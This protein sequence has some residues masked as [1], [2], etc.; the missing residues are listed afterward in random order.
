MIPSGFC[1]FYHFGLHS[2]LKP[3][4]GHKTGTH[5]AFQEQHAC[6]SV[7]WVIRRESLQKVLRSSPNQTV[8][9]PIGLN[10]A[11]TYQQTITVA[12]ER[13][14]VLIDISL[15]YRAC[16]PKEQ[17]PHEA[18]VEIQR[19]TLAITK[20]QRNEFQGDNTMSTSM[21]LRIYL[22]SLSLSLLIYNLG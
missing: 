18:G 6:S 12:S 17:D 2:L 3:S 15:I 7:S 8:S 9:S 19:K 13:E 14:L 1:S 16:L 21:A 5:Q 22:T 11:P 4:F 20:R 10:C